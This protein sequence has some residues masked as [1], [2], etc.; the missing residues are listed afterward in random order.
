[1]THFQQFIYKML[2]DVTPLFFFYLT[3]FGPVSTPIFNFARKIK[4]LCRNFP[5]PRS[6]EGLCELDFLEFSHLRQN[7]RTTRQCLK[8]LPSFVGGRILVGRLSLH[9]GRVEIL[10]LGSFSRLFVWQTL[11]WSGPGTLR[12]SCRS[13]GPL[14]TGDSSLLRLFWRGKE[15]FYKSLF[16]K[17][18]ND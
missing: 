17:V 4:S 15:S 12:T 6:V 14:T 13:L 9:G 16:K 8:T 2:Q 1:M 18:S 11:R 10:S 3:L 5:P 7:P